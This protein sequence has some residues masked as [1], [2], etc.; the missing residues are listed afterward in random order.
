ME[1]DAELN[2]IYLKNSGSNLEIKFKSARVNFAKF[3]A[4]V[5]SNLRNSRFAAKYLKVKHGDIDW[6]LFWVLSK[7]FRL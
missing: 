7:C 1:I 2:L 6:L 5:S 3:N 4:L